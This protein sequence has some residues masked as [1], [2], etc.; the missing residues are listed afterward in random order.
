[1]EELKRKAR[2]YDEALEKAK[3]LY[4]KG[5]ITESLCHIFPELAESEDERIRKALIEMVHDT[6]GDELWVDYGIHKEETLAWLEKQGEQKTE[7]KYVYTKFQIGDTIVEIKPNGYCQP[8]RVKY[9]G[10]GAYSCESDDGKR[11]LSFPIIN[12]D[13]YEL[14]EQKHAW[15]EEDEKKLNYLIALLQNSTMTNVALSATNEGIEDFLKSLKNRVQ[16]QPKQEWSEEDKDFIE[17]LIDVTELWVNGKSVRKLYSTALM[18]QEWLKSLKNRVQPQ[19]KREWSKEDEMKWSSVL[20]VLQN[21]KDN[22]PIVNVA[23]EFNWFKSLKERY[24]WKP[25]IEQ[26][27]AIRLARSFVVDDFSEKSTLSDILAELEKHLKKL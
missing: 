7:V 5:T 25:S 14:V 4:E 9:I 3:R 1:M 15:S 17:R 6:T 13:D 10:D 23:P 27:E 16:P 18:Y 22:Y 8:V 20:Q 21:I 19:P 24:T 2:A 12:Q 26:I 11:S